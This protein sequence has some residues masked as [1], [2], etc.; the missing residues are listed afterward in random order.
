MNFKI[1]ILATFTFVALTIMF[2]SSRSA[3][4]GSICHKTKGNLSI[5]NNGDGT[6]SGTITQGGQLNGT[7]QA[8]FT[9]MFT[10]TPDL[11]TFSFTDD[12]TITTYH[13]GVLRTHNVAIFDT[14]RGV[15][16]ALDRIDPNT[17]TGIFAGATGV[18]YINGRTP[19]GG[20]TIQAE[21]TGEICFAN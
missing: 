8:V 10:P 15:F 9:S 19:D 7:T 13:N 14:A 6:T 1:R 17:S 2:S 16:T 12:L 11:T 3:S 20:M 21:L 4:A 18:L 5:V